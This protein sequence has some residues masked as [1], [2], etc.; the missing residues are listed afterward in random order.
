MQGMYRPAIAAWDEVEQ[1]YTQPMIDLIM[2][3]DSTKR[4]PADK[5]MKEV[6]AKINK[7]IFN[8]K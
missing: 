3:A 8:T 1:T 4:V 7:E 5:G 6:A 2:S